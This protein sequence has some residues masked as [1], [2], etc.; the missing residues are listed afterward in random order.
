MSRLYH[1]V[2][3]ADWDAAADAYHGSAEDTRDGFLHFSTA[4][5]I[6]DSAAKHRRGERDLLLIAVDGDRLGDALK[7]E[8]SRGGQLFPHLYGPLPLAAVAW[9][10][11]LPLGD[12]GLH[13]FPVL[14]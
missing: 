2:R 4:A 1:L 12:D 9:T 7:W 8:A 10:R 6:V 13:C 11:P 5:Q 3:S 14:D